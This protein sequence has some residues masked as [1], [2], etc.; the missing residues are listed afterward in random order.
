MVIIKVSDDTVLTFGVD[1]VTGHACYGRVD[2][3]NKHI[4][5]ASNFRYLKEILGPVFGV[6]YNDYLTGNVN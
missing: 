1:T 6:R 3:P 4:Y 2:I 5:A